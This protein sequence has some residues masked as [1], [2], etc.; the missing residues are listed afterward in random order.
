MPQCE[1]GTTSEK[2]ATSAVRCFLS[3]LP[4]LIQS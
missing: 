4:W 2:Y 1:G 3:I